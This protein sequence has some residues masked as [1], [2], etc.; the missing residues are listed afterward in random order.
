MK[1]VVYS[2]IV[3]FLAIMITVAII[4]SQNKPRMV[5]YKDGVIVEVE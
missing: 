1:K 5:E 4:A 2:T 3:I